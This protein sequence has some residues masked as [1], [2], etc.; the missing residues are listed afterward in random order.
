MAPVD[1]GYGRFL[2]G[3]VDYLLF[4]VRRGPAPPLVQTI[5]PE[6]APIALATGDLPPGAATTI[7][8][9][10]IDQGTFTGVRA[11]IGMWLNNAATVGVDASYLRLFEE[12]TGFSIRSDGVPV[13]GR[14]FSDVAD[15]RTAF[16]VYALPDGTERGFI[17]INAPTELD[18]AD[19]NLRVRGTSICSDRL[20]VLF[21]LRYLRLRESIGINSGVVLADPTGGP[22]TSITSQELFDTENS[23]YGSQMGLETHWH[24]GCFT[25]DVSG[26]LAFGWVRQEVGISG[27]TQVATPGLPTEVLANRTILF[28]Q[29][30]NAGNY[31]RDRFAVLPELLIKLGYQITPHVRATV[32]YN[33]LVL[34]SVVRP[35]SAL[36]EGVNPSNTDFIAVRTPSTAPRPTFGFNG[37]DFWAQ[38]LTAGIVVTY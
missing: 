37:A 12:S 11:Q 33:L 8:G 9:N 20:D 14:G 13:I 5:P 36:D 28:V 29:P 17:N 23:F 34:T 4:K 19:L 38:G 1:E 27:T 21:G 15:G 16:L 35:G 32:G 30:T 10:N 26:K 25:L 31:E 24:Y 2:F 3:S 22:P 7:F 18:A 6:I